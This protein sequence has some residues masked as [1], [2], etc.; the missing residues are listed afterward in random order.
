MLAQAEALTIQ[1]P[2]RA[3]LEKRE[4]DQITPNFFAHQR[5]GF[6]RKAE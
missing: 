1:R 4:I 5:L 2:K 6:S 3:T